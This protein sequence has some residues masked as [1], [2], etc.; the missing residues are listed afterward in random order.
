M[1]FY[2]VLTT[3]YIFYLSLLVPCLVFQYV[4]RLAVTL[5]D[6]YK[7]LM[8]ALV[9]LNI[10]V[11]YFAKNEI[12]YIVLLLSVRSKFSVLNRFFGLFFLI[13]C[14]H[15]TKFWGGVAI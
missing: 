4:F 3:L 7:V 11:L 15:A 10:A 12:C 6:Q 5:L 9:S 14:C 2:F 13:F 8:V 1:V